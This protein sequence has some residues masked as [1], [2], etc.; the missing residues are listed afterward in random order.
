MPDVLVRGT[1]ET[2]TD[3]GPTPCNHRGGAWSDAAAEQGTPGLEDHHHQ[4]LGRDAEDLT[5]SLGGSRG[6]ADTLT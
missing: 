2:Q 6:P 1:E 4:M 3:A 5:Q